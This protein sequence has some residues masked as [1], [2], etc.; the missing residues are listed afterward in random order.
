VFWTRTTKKSNA[1]TASYLSAARTIAESRTEKLYL[2]EGRSSVIQE[3][4]ALNDRYWEKQ[5]SHNLYKG[6]SSGSPFSFV[7]TGGGFRRA[8]LPTIENYSYLRSREEG[9]SVNSLYDKG[10]IKFHVVIFGRMSFD[11]E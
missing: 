1:F 11:T 3:F 9:G 7:I 4:G 5:I 8:T 6:E 10:V 2:V